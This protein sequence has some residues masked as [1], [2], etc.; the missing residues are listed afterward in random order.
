MLCLFVGLECGIVGEF[1]DF[2]IVMKDVGLGGFL[3][4]VYGFSKVEIMC[5]DNGDGICLV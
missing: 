2:I 3:L 5:L 4:V 1:C